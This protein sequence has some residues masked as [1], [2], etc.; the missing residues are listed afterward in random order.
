MI[1]GYDL[2]VMCENIICACLPQADPLHMGLSAGAVCSFLWLLLLQPHA[3]DSTDAAPILGCSHFTYGLQVYLQQGVFIQVFLCVCINSRGGT[4]CMQ[5]SQIHKLC[6]LLSYYSV[7]HPHVLHL[8]PWLVFILQL[9]GDD[10]SDEEEDDSDSPKER[11]H[12]L[13]H[14][15][16]SGAR[17][18]ASGH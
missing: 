17:G 14:R 15:N 5:Q 1:H 3:V 7:V 6:V 11:N 10:R 8:P 2:S 13:S 4:K 16:G 12:K 9:E 18:R